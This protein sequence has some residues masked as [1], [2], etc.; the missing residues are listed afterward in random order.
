MA[1]W[2]RRGC[3]KGKTRQSTYY[4]DACWP[5]GGAPGKSEREREPRRRSQRVHAW[6]DVRESG[7]RGERLGAS[8]PH[9]RGGKCRTGV[10][11][12]VGVYPFGGDEPAA[13]GITHARQL[14][15]TD[16][17]PGP[18]A[19]EAEPRRR[20]PD[21]HVAHARGGAACGSRAS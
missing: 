15:G 4:A 14:A 8:T 20:H 13:L 18:I 7:D 10:P 3:E 2:Q 16:E 6:A 5:C 17:L 21:G 1:W 19:G 12:S 11:G 9:W